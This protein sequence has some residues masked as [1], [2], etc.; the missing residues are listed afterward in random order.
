M[1]LMTVPDDFI[2]A[3]CVLQLSEM[4]QNAFAS[5]QVVAVSPWR[6]YTLVSD[7][8]VKSEPETC[9]LLIS[10]LLICEEM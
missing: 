8:L 5:F 3:P 4:S 2:L 7:G 10:C 1:N 6:L 9:A